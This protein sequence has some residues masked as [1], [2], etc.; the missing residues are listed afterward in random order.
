MSRRYLT[1][2]LLLTVGAGAGARAASGGERPGSSCDERPTGFQTRDYWLHFK[3]PPALLPDQQFDGRPAKLE[4]HRVGPEYANGKCPGVPS[5]AAVLV[6][7]RSVAGSAAFDAESPGPSGG[8]LSLQEMLALEGVDTF[9]PS[10]LGYGRSTR[11]DQGLNDPGNASLPGFNADGS[12]SFAAGCDRTPLPAVIP[13][14]QQRTLLSVNPLAGDTRAHSSN[15][16]FATADVWVRDIRQVIDD[17]IARAAPN[18]GKVTLIGYSAGGQR[19]GRMLHTD[20]RLAAEDRFAPSKVATVVLV[21]SLFGG[22]TEEP[23]T[24]LPTF[25][26]TLATRANVTTPP[27]QPAGCRHVASGDPQRLWEQLMKQDSVGRNWGGEAFGEPTGLLRIP[28]FSGFYGWNSAVA[29]QLTTPT[30]VVHGLQDVTAQP[31]WSSD[32]YNALST[33]EKVLVR[34]QCSTHMLP[35]EGCSGALCAPT[36][37]APYGGRGGPWPGPRATLAAAIKEW[38]DHRTFEGAS[39]GRYI[40]DAHGV[41]RPAP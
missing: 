30:L 36:N 3:V 39:S 4:V 12:C 1:L 41:A 8:G 35:V 28:T 16:R 23:T 19:V 24:N 26:L 14:D 33:P 21:A 18:D 38:M 22:P 25:P 15:V 2:C 7:G 17:A 11:F 31:Q 29:S 37:G 13:L 32:I 9:A 10:L 6:H 5:Q 40:V 34:I 20:R 27:P